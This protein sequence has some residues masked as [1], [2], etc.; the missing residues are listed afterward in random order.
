MRQ[1][2]SHA[3]R[4]TIV[5]SDVSYPPTSGKRLRTLNLMLPLARRHEITYIGRGSLAPTEREAAVFFRDHGV[6]P[7]IV[8]EPLAA[9]AGAAFY[10]RLARNIFAPAPYSIAS[11]ITPLMRETV[12]E[13]L[14]R[15]APDVCQIEWV[16][17]L[18]TAEGFQGA[19]VLQ[20]HNVELLIWKRYAET[21]SNLAKRAFIRNQWRKFVRYE[22]EAFRRVSRV[23]AVSEADKAAA[24]ALYGPLPMDVVDN[25]VDVA[26]FGGIERKPLG[27]RIIFLGALDWRPNLDAIGVLLDEIFPAV[28]TKIPDAELAIVG[29]LP[30]KSLAQKISSTAG[31]ALFAD[32][33]DVKPFLG[34]SSVMSVPLRVGGGSRLKIL[35]AL[36]AGLPVVSTT[37]GAEGLDLRHGVHLIIADSFE[38]QS[39]ALCDALMRAGQAQRMAEQGRAQ[40]GRLYDWSMLADHLE[41]AWVRAMR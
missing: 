5:D 8:P 10:G 38:D 37:I 6:T 3:M 19:K 16:G 36:A 26:G 24:Q 25:G 2:A 40:V 12:R 15:H 34:S 31:A 11:H 23:V 27:R 9:K 41:A 28:R 7:I 35:E 21:E 20:A 29:R 33:A 22:G 39:A 14:L 32:V 30:S 18:Y 4:V 1:G 17:Y 13:H